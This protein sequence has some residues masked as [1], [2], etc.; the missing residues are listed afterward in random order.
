MVYDHGLLDEESC[1]AMSAPDLGRLDHEV[2]FLDV[3][4]SDFAHGLLVW[5]SCDAVSAQPPALLEDV[6]KLLQVPASQLRTHLEQM[7]KE[8]Q[9]KGNEVCCKGPSSLI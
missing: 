6:V 1:G 7:Q 2:K 4:A 3:Q 5:K 8:G 9:D